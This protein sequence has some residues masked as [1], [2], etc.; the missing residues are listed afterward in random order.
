[1]NTP[2][3]SNTPLASMRRALMIALVCVPVIAGCGKSQGELLFMLGLG[4]GQEVEA[5]FRLT[6]GRVLI[7]LDDASQRVG[8]PSTMRTLFDDLAQELLSHEAASKIIPHQTVQHLRQSTPE[9]DR[10][11]AREVGELVG[12]EQV[13]WIEVQDYLGE[14]QIREATNAAYFTVTVKVLDVLETTKRT[15]VRL[16]PSSSKGRLVS[17]SLDGSEVVTKKTKDAVAKEL[18]H[19]L[20]IRIAK[21]FYDYRLG[22]FEREQ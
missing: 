22:D 13:L 18:A 10:L 8:W 4:Q 6:E 15:R 21:L 1:M 2:S 7:L 16:W 14:S 5:K 11:G 12:A 9:L 17:V 3:I 19:R 20:A